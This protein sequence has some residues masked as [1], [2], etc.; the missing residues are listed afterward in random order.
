[1]RHYIL[2]IVS[3]IVICFAAL[4]TFELSSYTYHLVAAHILVGVPLSEVEGFQ[5]P[6]WLLTHFPFLIVN[7]CAFAALITI[8]TRQK[9]ISSP[10]LVTLAISTILFNGFIWIRN[11]E[12]PLPLQFLLEWIS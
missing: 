3:T 9:R 11:N 5:L 8:A 2:L 1:M 12:L 7:V 10:A 6:D 4:D